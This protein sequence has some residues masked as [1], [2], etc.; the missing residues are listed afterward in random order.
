MPNGADGVRALPELRIIRSSGTSPAARSTSS[1]A[2][3]GT[4]SRSRGHRTETTMTNL[5][6]GTSSV[7]MPRPH[8]WAIASMASMS[9]ATADPATRWAVPRRMRGTSSPITKGKGSSSSESRGPPSSPTRSVSSGTLGIDLGGDGVTHNDAG[10]ADSGANGLQNF[11]IIDSAVIV[12]S[13]LTIIGTLDSTPNATFHLQFFGDDLADPSGFGEGQTLLG[14]GLYDVS[15]D[16][17]GHAGF[18]RSLSTRRRGSSR[19]RPR[20]RREARRNSLRTSPR[21]PR[22]P[23]WTFP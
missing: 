22:K 7:P 15:T 20:T 21:R 2:T 17:S 12:G 8:R 19:P 14:A 23:T 4:A 1:R 18:S 9:M 3:A 11:P 5:V 6:Q 16:A 13:K 10:D